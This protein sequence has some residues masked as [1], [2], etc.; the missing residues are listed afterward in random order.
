[1]AV[2]EVGGIDARSLWQVVWVLLYYLVE[3]DRLEQYHLLAVW[4]ELEGIYTRSIV[5]QFCSVG[6]IIYLRTDFSDS[7]IIAFFIIGI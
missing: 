2:H 7:N 6:A 4:R 3:W 5:C 1:M